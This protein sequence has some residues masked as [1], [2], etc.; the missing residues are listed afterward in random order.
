M[1]VALGTSTAMHICMLKIKVLLHHQ[2]TSKNL[3]SGWG[4]DRAKYTNLQKTPHMRRSDITTCRST[5]E[6][7]T[8]AFSKALASVHFS[9]INWDNYNKINECTLLLLI[10]RDKTSGEDGCGVKLRFSLP[11][12]QNNTYT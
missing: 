12:H 3:K 11:Y 2:R 5:A 1:L 4:M 10:V 6:I 7:S 8:S 9:E